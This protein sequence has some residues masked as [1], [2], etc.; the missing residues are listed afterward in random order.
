MVE[1][2]VVGYTTGDE[3]STRDVVQTSRQHSSGSGVIVDPAGYIM[4]DAHVV[5]G[6]VKVKVVVTARGSLKSPTP[7]AAALV[8]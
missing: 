6:A 7:N 1:V 5:Q 3:G 8:L 2:H 4:T